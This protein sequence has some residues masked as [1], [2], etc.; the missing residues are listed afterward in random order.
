MDRSVPPKP[1]VASSRFA[2]ENLVV[3][4][5]RSICHLVQAVRVRRTWSV[6]LA[7]VLLVRLH[8]TVIDKSLE[9]A[10]QRLVQYAAASGAR[11]VPV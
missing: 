3:A 6:D 1:H 9:I 2:G 7:H 5:T 11:Q 4:D 10:G 8:S